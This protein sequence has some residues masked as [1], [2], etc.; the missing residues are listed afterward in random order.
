M[1]RG[2]LVTQS[3]IVADLSPENNSP[4]AQS[5]ERYKKIIWLSIDKL[6]SSKEMER[7]KRWYKKYFPNIPDNASPKFIQLPKPRKKPKKTENNFQE[8]TEE[9]EVPVES[10]AMKESK[11]LVEIINMARKIKHLAANAGKDGGVGDIYFVRNLVWELKGLMSTARQD[12]RDKEIL[13]TRNMDARLIYEWA[14]DIERKYSAK[15]IILKDRDGA[16]VRGN[17]TEIAEWGQAGVLNI[18]GLDRHPIF[19]DVLA[20]QAGSRQSDAMYLGILMHY[21][22]KVIYD[23]L[24]RYLNTQKRVD[25]RPT[26]LNTFDDLRLNDVFLPEAALIQKRHMGEYGWQPDMPTPLDAITKNDARGF[27][28]EYTMTPEELSLRVG[29]INSCMYALSAT[30]VAQIDENVGDDAQKYKNMMEIR[31]IISRNFSYI[32]A[33]IE[34][35]LYFFEHEIGFSNVRDLDAD[36]ESKTRLYMRFVSPYK[37]EVMEELDET[38]KRFGLRFSTR[39][40]FSLRT[41]MVVRG[42]KTTIYDFKSTIHY[43]GSF[44]DKIKAIAYVLAEILK[45]IWGGSFSTDADAFVISKITFNQDTVT[46]ILSEL[47]NYEFYFWGMNGDKVLVEISPEDIM[48]FLKLT[49][50]YTQCKISSKT[51]STKEEREALELWL[52]DESHNKVIS[53]PETDEEA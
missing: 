21:L 17:L 30:I 27:Y 37:Y 36:F 41:D 6:D 39:V 10:V 18:N 4:H 50:L 45:K 51:E 12:Q 15:F 25:P 20:E 5:L 43:D 34:N 33:A 14:S 28:R 2:D 42:E 8:E 48:Q 7:M 3:Q 32:L 16:G 26:K 47:K 13:D 31:N 1:I 9:P 29:L 40:G 11:R 52:P 44:E 19:M 49:K 23:Y 35:I 24:E 22:P 46:E 38:L 53:S